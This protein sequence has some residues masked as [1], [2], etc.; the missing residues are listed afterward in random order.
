MC[1]SVLNSSFWISFRSTETKHIALGFLYAENERFELL[2]PCGTLVFKT[3]AF[4][5]SANSPRQRYTYFFIVKC[6]IK[7]L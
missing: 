1:F 3:S 7:K 6:F 5:H 4:D 2:V